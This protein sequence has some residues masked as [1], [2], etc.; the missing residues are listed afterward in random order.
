MMV[1][2]KTNQSYITR[3]DYTGPHVIAT[4]GNVG[5]NVTIVV[6]SQSTAA[7]KL[8]TEQPQKTLEKK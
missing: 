4:T 6:D 5:I 2:H 8:T 1:T 3:T 7:K